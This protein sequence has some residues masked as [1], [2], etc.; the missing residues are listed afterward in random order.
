MDLKTRE[1]DNEMTPYCINIYDG[2]RN[3]SIPS[4]S[5]DFKKA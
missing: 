3:I 4:Y 5:T 1:I 2:K